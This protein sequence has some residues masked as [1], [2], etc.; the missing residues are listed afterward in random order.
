MNNKGYV[1][2]N[3][4]GT[5]INLQESDA[6]WGTGKKYTTQTTTLD[7]ATVFNV[8]RFQ[9]EYTRH[10]KEVLNTLLKV[11]TKIPATVE[12]VRTVTLVKGEE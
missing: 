11:C 6:S 2:M 8:C 12:T 5:F 10:Y 3:D 1:L 9:G 4:K 7:N